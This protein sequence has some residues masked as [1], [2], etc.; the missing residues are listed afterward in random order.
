M[1]LAF[2]LGP[3]SAAG[4]SLEVGF[5]EEVIYYMMP[6]HSLA[7]LATGC[8]LFILRSKRSH[9]A[10]SQ[11]Q[12]TCSRRVIVGLLSIRLHELHLICIDCAAGVISQGIGVKCP[13][14]GSV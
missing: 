11:L 5:A 6:L 13:L 1:H 12:C 14:D 8:L 4:A 9:S 7:L 3:A 2:G 10:R